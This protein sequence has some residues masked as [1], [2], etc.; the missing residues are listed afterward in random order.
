MPS[1][2]TRRRR[3]QRRRGTARDPQATRPSARAASSVPHGAH[4]AVPASA[5]GRVTSSSD[6]SA[7]PTSSSEP[8]WRPAVEPQ[9]VAR[10]DSL[11]RVV[12]AGPSAPADSDR[13]PDGRAA[14]RRR[15]YDAAGAGDVA[16]DQA[17][18]SVAESSSLFSSKLARCT[19]TVVDRIAAATSRRRHDRLAAQ[20]GRWWRS[21]DRAR[22]RRPSA[23]SLRGDALVL[24]V[25][26]R[27]TVAGR[28]PEPCLEA[29][30]GERVRARTDA[31][32]ARRPTPREGTSRPGAHAGD[33]A[34]RRASISDPG[35]RRPARTRRGR[36][37][38]VVEAENRP[39]A[40]SR[41]AST[42]QKPAS[43]Q[44]RSR[45]STLHARR[46][47]VGHAARGSRSTTATCRRSPEIGRG[48]VIV[49]RSSSASAASSRPERAGRRAMRGRSARRR[50]R[51]ARALETR[52]LQQSGKRMATHDG[53]CRMFASS[54]SQCASS[55]TRTPIVTSPR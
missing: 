24:R 21:P 12:A 38:A 52:P 43:T 40:A 48:P 20:R 33:G 47:V 45:S 17:R 6:S 9:A 54:S 39:R 2:R 37:R 10:V 30:D 32:C 15:R 11:L 31:P 29:G 44:K 19:G 49:A 5:L 3:L 8:R 46:A 1:K 26:A 27:R 51:C 28:R 34:E 42:P 25:R 53:P 7:S 36:A 14:R 50:A 55:A 4:R 13:L 16:N 35:A 18:V 41:G 23:A 22:A